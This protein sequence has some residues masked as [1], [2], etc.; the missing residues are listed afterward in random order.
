[1][2]GGHFYYKQYAISQ[3]IDQ[4]Q[5]VISN[6]KKPDAVNDWG[7][8]L[9]RGYSPET[10]AEFGKAVDCLQHALVY[11]QRIDWLLSGDDGENEFHKRLAE[12]LQNIKK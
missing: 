8:K 6:E 11:V 3:L 4:V 2:S 10:I 7:D 12:E 5:H 1:M 9:C